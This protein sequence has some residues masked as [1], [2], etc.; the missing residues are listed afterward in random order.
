MES[1][2]VKH[3]LHWPET[4]SSQPLYLMGEY[5]LQVGCTLFECTSVLTAV[6]FW[7]GS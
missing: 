4:Q 5:L 7:P 1:S 2:I 3:D 6:L